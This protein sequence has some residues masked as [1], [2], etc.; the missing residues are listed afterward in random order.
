[1]FLF[2]LFLL[3]FWAPFVAICVWLCGGRQ[4]LVCA[5]GERGL[6]LTLAVFLS[7][8]SN[9]LL[10]QALLANR[11]ALASQLALETPVPF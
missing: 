9:Y 6:G 7:C 4:I 2:F 8:S 11:A 3:D 10:R 1:M 5:C